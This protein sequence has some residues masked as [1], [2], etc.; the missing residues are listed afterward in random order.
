MTKKKTKASNY[1]VGLFKENIQNIDTFAINMYYSYYYHA[2]LKEAKK[3]E[4][5]EDL[6]PEDLDY[7]DEL[8][9]MVSQIHIL[10]LE[11]M[12]DGIE[13]EEVYH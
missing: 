7:Y 5:Q 8:F 12:R 9:E 3:I 6:E 4:K 1:I 10:T 13:Q 11:N 2:F